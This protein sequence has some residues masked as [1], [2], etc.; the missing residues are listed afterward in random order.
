MKSRFI[1]LFIFILFAFCMFTSKASAKYLCSYGG[2]S[3]QTFL[4]EDY[5]QKEM[6]FKDAEVTIEPH[7]NTGSTFK[8]STS[9]YYQN[10]NNKVSRQSA[11]ASLKN[12]FTVLYDGDNHESINYDSSDTKYAL[13]N[14]GDCPGNITVIVVGGEKQGFIVVD[15]SFNTLS[16]GDF[17]KYYENESYIVIQAYLE[18]ET[19]S[20][21]ALYNSYNSNTCLSAEEANYYINEFNYVS[22]MSKNNLLANMYKNRG[23][24]TIAKDILGKYKVGS[25]CYS[26]NPD[27][28]STYSQLVNSAKSALTVI[29]SSIDPNADDYD[30]ECQYILGDPSTPGSFA[31]YLDITFRFIKFLAPIAV[32]VLSIFDYIKAISSSDG[33]LINKTNI[34]TIKRLVIALILFVL[35][36]IISYVLTLLGVQGRCDFNNIAGI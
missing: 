13:K 24:G 18:D 7:N 31:Y 32:I 4:S 33:D 6:S 3:T 27:L 25:D 2:N 21:S 34:K 20:S 17:L 23:F 12:E 36:I 8:V 16:I 11:S 19:F 1:K 9:F 22:K 30:N 29:D 5:R 35:P 26:Q 14:E 28:Q 15:I 10:K